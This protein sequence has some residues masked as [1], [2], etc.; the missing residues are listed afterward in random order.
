MS[1][2]EGMAKPECGA[3]EMIWKMW[4]W[5]EECLQRAECIS[6]RR[7]QLQGANL[8]NALPGISLLCPG[9]HPLPVEQEIR[10]APDNDSR[11]A[12]AELLQCPLIQ[13]NTQT[14]LLR[15]LKATVHELKRAENKI[16]HAQQLPHN[17]AGQRC[18][19]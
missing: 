6:A 11:S 12:N 19:L 10:H 14:R 7:Q 8:R 4:N 5:C 18:R 17:I 13:F 15:D 1:R 9:G 3:E 2:N 16:I